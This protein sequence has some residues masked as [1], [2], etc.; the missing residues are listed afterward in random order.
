MKTYKHTFKVV[1]VFAALAVMFQACGSSDSGPK[2]LSIDAI[3]VGGEDLNGATSP[4]DVATDASVTITFNSEIKAETANSSNITLTQ[5]YDDSAVELD[6]SVSGK[7]L[8]VTPVSEL[9]TGILYLVELKAG[10]T[11]TDDQPIGQ[12]SRTFTTTG[13][14]APSGMIANWTF[15]D[16]S[17]DVA[18]SYN[19]TANG[20]VDITYTASRNAEAGK[21]ATFNG[22]TSIIEIPGADALINSSDFTLS[23]WFKTNSDGHVDANGNPAGHFVMGLGAFHGLQFEIGGAYDFAKF[24]IQYEFGAAAEAESGAEDMWFPV[25]ATDA[26]NGGWQGW[27]FAKSLTASEMEAYLKDSWTHVTYVYSSTEKS[28]KLYYDGELMKSFDFDLWP[29]GDA[30]TTVVGLTYAGEEPDVVNEL[31][32]GFVHSRAG[33]MWDQEPWGGYDNA[34]ANHFKGQ[35]DDIKIYHKV[36]TE[37]EIQLMYDSEN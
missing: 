9:G 16:T 17:D 7:T 20:V 1:A 25:E 13:N 5:D 33:T 27:D 22:N 2:D 19:P 31:A 24:A 34:T 30:K 36:L 28:G 15:E 12:T 14:F 23:F 6:I 21:A 8:T 3:T 29:E 18:G 37:T 10:L 4:N 35:L 11:N 26:S 32:L